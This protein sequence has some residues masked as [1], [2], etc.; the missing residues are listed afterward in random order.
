M[1]PFTAPIRYRFMSAGVVM[2]SG[3]F[4]I[5]PVGLFQL[6]CRPFDSLRHR[7]QTPVLLVGRQLRQVPGSDLGSSGQ[8]EHFFAQTHGSN[9]KPK[10]D[11][12]K[13]EL[14]A[15]QG[16]VV[17]MPVRKAVRPFQSVR[18]HELLV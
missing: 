17:R 7:Q 2:V 4:K 3:D 6:V 13:R 14:A 9:V 15:P 1:V 11:L 5:A 12:E 18:E 10:R 8:I 16:L